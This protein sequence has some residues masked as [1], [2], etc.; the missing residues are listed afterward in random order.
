MDSIRFGLL[1]LAT[2]GA[3]GR[4]RLEQRLP[5]LPPMLPTARRRVQFVLWVAGL[6]TLLVAFV[7]L[8]FSHVLSSTLFGSMLVMYAMLPLVYLSIIRWR[9]R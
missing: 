2:I 9:Q 3:F 5:P 6:V 8:R 7:V 4:Q 1:A